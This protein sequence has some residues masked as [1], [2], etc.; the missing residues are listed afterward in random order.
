MNGLVPFSLGFIFEFSSKNLISF[1]ILG[2]K[3]IVITLRNRNATYS[4]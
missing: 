4:T 1:I 2:I 3:N